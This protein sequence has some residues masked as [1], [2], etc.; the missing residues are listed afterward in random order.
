MWHALSHKR[1]NSDFARHPDVSNGLV[2][3]KNCEQILKLFRFVLFPIL[4]IALF[5]SATLPNKASASENWNNS[6]Q[7]ERYLEKSIPHMMKH[8]WA[9]HVSEEGLEVQVSLFFPVGLMERDN[10]YDSVSEHWKNSD[11][12]K[13]KKYPGTVQFKQLDKP[14]KIVP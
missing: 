8:I 12:V 10:I 5:S 11:F 1:L 6:R 2:L 14:L 3:F 13:S 9:T 7:F 4:F